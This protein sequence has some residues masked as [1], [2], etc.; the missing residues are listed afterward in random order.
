[1]G[2]IPRFSSSTGS[3]RD[4]VSVARD[5]LPFFRSLFLFRLRFE[6]PPR[7]PTYCEPMAQYGDEESGWV[8]EAEKIGKW[9][10]LRAET[11]VEIRWCELARGS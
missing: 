9:W 4:P 7:R 10:V 3:Q 6:F 8:A 1:M 2:R 11:A 5:S